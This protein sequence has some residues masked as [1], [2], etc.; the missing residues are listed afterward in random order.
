LEEAEAIQTLIH[1]RRIENPHYSQRE[2]ARELGLPK[3][4]VNEM[5]TL[6]KLPQDMKRSVRTWD[7]VPK[8]LLLLL[9]RQ[10]DEKNI[11]E[12]YRK[13]KEGKLTVREAKTR[14]KKSKSRRG[15]PRYYQYTFQA[16][17]KDFTLRIKFKKVKVD[18]SECQCKVIMS[19]FLQNRNVIPLP[20]KLLFEKK[21]TFFLLEAQ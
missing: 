9:M 15:R 20:V 8:S 1:N 17:E 3:S 2:A 19:P 4:Y 6:L 12:F 14:L 21:Q 7:T 5:L 13:I 18:Q 16:P 10:G 11:R